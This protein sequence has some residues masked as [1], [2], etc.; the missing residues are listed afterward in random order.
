MPC[1]AS[2]WLVKVLVLA[3]G[4]FA[5]NTAFGVEK[6]TQGD[7]DKLR[8][9]AV[10][11]PWEASDKEGQALLSRIGSLTATQGP[12]NKIVTFKGKTHVVWQDSVEDRYYA[13]IRSLDRAT[14]TW[15]PT[16][17]LLKADW[18][19]TR[20]NISID[21]KG[22]LHVVTREQYI[23]SVHPNDASQ[24]T[25]PV[26]LYG[27]YECYPWIVCGPDDA[28]YVTTGQ[29]AGHLGID[30]YVNPAGENKWIFRGMLF[31]KPQGYKHYAAFQHGLAWGPDHRTLHMSIGAFMGIYAG[32]ELRGHHQA[33]A[34]MCSH[35]F[36]QTWERADGTP[37]E[38][39]ATMQTI[40]VLEEGMR[41]PDATDTSKPGIYHGD[42]V[43]D[44]DGRPYVAYVRHTPH[45]GRLYLKTPDERGGWKELPV[46]RAI[47]KN[48]P[49]MGVIEFFDMTMAGQ[50]VLCLALELIPFDHPAAEWDPGVYGR[51]ARWAFDNPEAWRIGWLESRDG[52]RTFTARQPVQHDP[53]STTWRPRLEHATGFNEV[54]YPASFVYAG[55]DVMFRKSKT[56]DSPVYYVE[57]NK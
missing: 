13:Q 8:E 16:Y 1:S 9:L 12:G 55:G 14:G 25:E 52:G 34:Y 42:V 30:F 45:R 47:S 32:R 33:I 46:W 18:D 38:L 20:P 3:C 48:W 44:R 36:G 54:P 21:S 15:S 22:Y 50:D 2:R 56:V 43:T 5:T 4:V 51:P 10:A 49:G 23:R 53:N 19:H 29:N 39:P 35:D 31:R 7:V 28:I 11:D 57:V 41:D 27:R 24:W 17:T 37:I 40:D 26:E 6:F